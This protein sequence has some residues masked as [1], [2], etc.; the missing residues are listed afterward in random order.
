MERLD[1]FNEVR[2]DIHYFEDKD[3]ENN[4]IWKKYSE[5]CFEFEKKERG[6]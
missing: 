4:P 5:S 3:V 2:A 1:Y 6:W